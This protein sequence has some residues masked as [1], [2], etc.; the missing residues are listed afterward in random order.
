MKNLLMDILAFG[1]IFSS[2]LVITSKNPVIAV[3]FLISVFV[4]A[5]GYLI[6]LGIGFIGISYIIVYIGAITVLF[7]FVIMMINIRLSDITEVGSQYSKSLPLALAIASLFIYEIFTI[8]PFS[9]NN[10]S[11]IST[12]F[13]V[14][15]NLNEL[16]LNSELSYTD[17]VYT[18]PAMVDTTITNFLQIES[19]GLFIYTYGAI[20]LI[21][22]S[23]VLLLAMVAP[24]FITKKS[25]FNSYKSTPILNKKIINIGNLKKNKSYFSSILYDIK[26]SWHLL[27]LKI[28][29]NINLLNIINIIFLVFI[30]Y[31]FF[32]G[33]KN[34]LL[35]FLFSF[36]L[37]LLISSYVLNNF[38]YSDNI[39][40]R[41]LQKFVF[42]N[43]FL[44]SF[45]T[46]GHYLGFY[47]V[48]HCSSN[49]GDKFP[50]DS[51]TKNKSHNIISVIKDL[52]KDNND[53]YTVTVSKEFVDKNMTVIGE[54]AKIA[55]GTVAPNAAAGAA[56]GTVAAAAL[57]AS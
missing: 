28:Y 47:D 21:I 43:I 33:L 30:L 31:K 24:I 3:I 1:T 2:V 49:D 6:I 18:Q 44:I 38:K 50:D 16:F 40:V 4:N 53:Q 8:I 32:V 36:V 26:S 39:I 9:F 56:A 12:L 5:A 41:F 14:L 48:T 20:W 11:V 17:I 7:L 45:W 54:A 19:I 15:G 57:K 37:S 35:P 55:A 34:G 42:L 27:I 22:T 23:V 10:V 51:N 29:K 25:T 13:N 46:L 52:N